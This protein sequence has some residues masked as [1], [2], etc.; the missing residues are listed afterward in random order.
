MYASVEV[1][2]WDNFVR[3]VLPCRYG[4]SS[5]VRWNVNGSFIE[6]SQSAS[7]SPKVFKMLVTVPGSRLYVDV[8]NRVALLWT[9]SMELICC[10]LY[11]S[12]TADDYSRCG[13][14]SVR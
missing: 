6:E 2:I 8:A 13:R 7:F 5:D 9:I 3:V 4:G 10:F 11:G 14:T 12:H 1:L